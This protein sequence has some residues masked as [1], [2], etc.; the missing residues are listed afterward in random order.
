MNSDDVLN[1]L[2]GR[3]GETL[4]RQNPP[5]PV[6]EPTPTPV[7]EPEQPKQRRAEAIARIIA[8]SYAMPGVPEGVRKRCAKHRIE[9]EFGAD[10]ARKYLRS[11]NKKV[12]VPSETST[13]SV[14]PAASTPAPA[15]SSPTATTTIPLFSPPAATPTATLVIANEL[16]KM[17]TPAQQQQQSESETATQ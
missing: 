13:P 16:S 11:H 4:V 1:A 9:E 5:A 7:A 14:A 2:L 15:A 6:P 8:E 12:A 10:E 17:L 3:L